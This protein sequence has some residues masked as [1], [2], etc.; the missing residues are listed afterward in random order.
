MAAD[1]GR[2][3]VP[4]A[5][6]N[7]LIRLGLVLFLLG[8]VTGLV[9]PGFA[10]PRM[11]LSSHLQGLTNGIFLMVMGLVWPRL[12]ARPGRLRLIALLLVFGTYANWVTT[13]LAGL[14]GAGG[15]MM[16]LAAAGFEGTAWQEAVVAAGLISLSAA[17]I[18]GVVLAILA[19]R[20]SRGA[21]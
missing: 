4:G 8:L 13:L 16:P 21:S 18:A 12:E 19:L 3:E 15:A 1:R 7:G 14:W 17:M 6:G 20:P 9:L 2:E 5:P 11:G 10:N